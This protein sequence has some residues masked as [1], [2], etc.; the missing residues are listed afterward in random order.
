MDIIRFTIN[1]PVK[2][3]VGVLL[4]C[5]F[6]VLALFQ[7]PIQ[8]TPNVDEPRVTVTT[9]WPGK[10]AREV[11]RE[12]IERQ[13]EKLKGVPNLRKMTST[14]RE[15]QAEVELE[16]FVGV[17]KDV[18]LRDTDEKLNQVSNYPPQVE[19]PTIVAADAALATPIAWLIFRAQD[20]R[21]VSTMRDFVWDHVKPI[22][23]R[24]D[25]LASVDVFGGREREVQVLIDAARLAARGLTLRD[26]EQ[27]LSGENAN[28]S[29]GTMAT[30]KRDFIYRTVGEYE[31]VDQIE[32]TVIA[33]RDGGP[34][35]VR[36]VGR[37][38]KTHEK[39][40]GFVRSRGEPVLGMP[41]R[42]ET[43]AN[44]ISV[45][46]GLRE[47]IDK[48]NKEILHPRGL[49]LELTQVYDETVYINSSIDLVRDNLIYGGM[50]AAIV[51]L[52]FLR[53][54]RAT[55]VVAVSIPI[56]VIGTFLA[57]TMLGRN[58]NV[59]ML[60]GMAFAVGM[61][62]DNA[63]VVL[64]NI[65]RHR[66]MG[67][68]SFQAAQ[69][70]ATEVWG[71]VLASTL[72][73]MAVFIP[74][75]FIE[76]E[77]GQL[78]R[79]IAI[80]ISAGVFLSMVVSVLVIPTLSARVLGGAKSALKEHK[81]G[82]MSRAVADLVS[83]AGRHWYVKLPVIA[84]FVLGSLFGSYYLKPPT[85][86]LPSGNRNLV[87]GFLITEPGLSPDEFETMAHDIEAYLRPYWEAELGSPEAEALPPVELPLGGAAAG[88][89][90]ATVK[91]KPAPIEN[92]F[93]VN[94][95]NTCF[96][97]ATSKDPL[98]VKPL[99]AVLTN[100]AYASKRTVGSFAVFF[101]TGLFGGVRSGN[102][103]DLEVRGPDLDEVNEA[104][105]K[106]F[107]ACM[108]AGLGM[109]QPEPNNFNLLRP[110]IRA[111]PDR[112]RAAD[113]GMTVRDI[114]FV[115]EAAVDG[116][117][118]G[119]FR[120]EGDEIDMVVKL[121][122][123]DQ[124]PVQNVRAV[125]VYARSGA[126]VPLESVVNFAEV[127]APQQINHIE[128]MPGVTLRIRL[129]GG[130]ALESAMTTLENDIIGRMREAGQI[131][132]SIFTSLAGNADKLVQTRAA[133]FG[134]WTGWNAQSILALVQSRGFLALLITYLLMAALFESF[135]HPISIMLTVPLAA[136][137]GFAGLKLVY[138]MSLQDPVQPIQQL[139][140]VTMLGFVI[141]LGIVVNNAILIVHQS[142]NN[143]TYGMTPEQA[144]HE[145]IHT[146]LRPIF[147][148]ALTTVF[149][150]LPLALMPGAGSELYRGLAAV[151]VGGLLVATVFTLILIPLVFSTLLHV[152]MAVAQW[153]GREDLYGARTPHAEV[154]PVAAGPTASPGP[155]A[156]PAPFT[157]GPAPSAVGG[158]H[159][160]AAPASAG[161]HPPPAAPPPTSGHPSPAA[162]H[163]AGGQASPPSPAAT[164][165]AARP[166]PMPLSSDG[167]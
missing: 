68:S 36:D 5:L 160:P 38:I 33:Y 128:E 9:L 30:G 41:A 156:V 62:V 58:L 129:P 3:A 11:E 99:Q 29:A 90:A 19:R 123:P 165:G 111:I 125:P 35:Y 145:S 147:M 149:G 74:V 2:V 53:N 88:P 37:A 96:M 95:N 157:P 46:A 105:G 112:A 126:I 16:F 28:V 12:I 167:P 113:I 79:D 130:V 48:V 39:R 159:A 154:P 110:E 69:D 42:R 59:V 121:E 135:V 20:G 94:F 91:V 106:L 10:S 107:V 137:G 32:N 85:D 134:R 138:W 144:I 153:M 146:R 52:L 17:D 64:E 162:P 63:V 93:F 47:Q 163:P 4:M 114:G 80:A 151:M 100:A 122:N 45:M 120:D 101:Q 102:T 43:G 8:L 104:A 50:L 22:L 73:T 103:I 15:G 83:L 77:A 143:L 25:G 124:S 27:A 18:A 161:G 150:Q 108:E 71:A 152:R 49:G 6:G 57:V 60:A 158:T 44:V 132:S 65:Y 148:T 142:L 117:Y 136:V 7:L 31:T 75:I 109:P 127:G 72:T 119:G 84:L 131:D 115:V 67:K 166:Q 133:M 164:G 76:E 51:L 34:V 116:A 40:T 97:G 139:D 86:Y 89:G 66:Q 81:G 141:L 82:R 1:N 155:R 24:V 140:V 78:F 87:F 26:L 14:A 118:V 54:F 70:G 21:D 56:S 23:E 98:N 55:G 92:F 13:E 61:V